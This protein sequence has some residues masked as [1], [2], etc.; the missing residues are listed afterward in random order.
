MSN[1]NTV[2]Q[3]IPQRNIDLVNGFV[4]EITSISSVIPTEINNLCLCFVNVN[5]DNFDHKTITHEIN[6]DGSFVI[7]KKYMYQRRVNIYL[8]NVANKGTHIWKF[9]LIFPESED[10]EFKHIFSQTAIGIFKTK[11][12]IQT[13]EAFDWDKH[14][15]D[16]NTGYELMHYGHVTNPDPT[17]YINNVWKDFHPKDSLDFAMND[18]DEITMKLNMNKLTL[19][20]EVNDVKVAEIKDLEDTSYRAVVS[21]DRNEDGWELLS[22]QHIF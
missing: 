12:H 3:H 8:S 22:Y 14:D 20:L 6:H 7:Y 11:Y 16:T 17:N 4:R 1:E 10:N 2:K 9:T 13:S 5:H 18:N 15:N 19:S 21:I